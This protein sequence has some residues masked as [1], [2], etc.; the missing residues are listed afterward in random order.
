M[1]KIGIDDLEALYKEGDQHGVRKVMED[2]GSQIKNANEMSLFMT[3]P[4]IVC[5]AI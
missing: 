1:Q 4:Q 2:I 3:R 5:Y